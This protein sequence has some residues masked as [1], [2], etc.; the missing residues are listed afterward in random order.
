[1]ITLYHTGIKDLNLYYG[2][3]CWTLNS[4]VSGLLVCHCN[5]WPAGPC[6]SHNAWLVSV[7]DAQKDI[8]NT[9][10]SQFKVS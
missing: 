8:P 10:E 6:V 7:K 4:G 3:A 2:A 5:A 9:V 1:M